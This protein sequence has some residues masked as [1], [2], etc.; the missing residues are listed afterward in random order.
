MG[1][2]VI[3]NCPLQLVET[4]NAEDDYSFTLCE[5]NL[6][7]VLA[8]VKEYT[9]CLFD[10][11]IRVIYRRWDTSHFCHHTLGPPPFPPFRS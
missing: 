9:D 10:Y 2:G 3:E 4:G 5:D 6:D 11:S 8:K 1:E 7:R